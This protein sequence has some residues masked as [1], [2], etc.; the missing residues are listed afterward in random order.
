MSHDTVAEHIRRIGADLAPKLRADR[1]SL[2]SSGSGPR[3]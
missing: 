1:E 2:S 3:G